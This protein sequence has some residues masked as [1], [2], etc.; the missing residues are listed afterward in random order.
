MVHSL[1]LAGVAIAATTSLLITAGAAPGATSK[2]KAGHWVGHVKGQS[3]PVFEFDYAKGKVSGE[4]GTATSNQTT[5]PG[6]VS[7]AV[8]PNVIKVKHGHFKEASNLYSPPVLVTVKGTFTSKT[9]AKGYMS[10]AW[11]KKKDR[12]CSAKTKWRATWTPPST[13]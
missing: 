7:F 6:A 3:D 2:P 11:P 1:R 4:I 10:T 13:N 9:T 8:P 5:C 12:K